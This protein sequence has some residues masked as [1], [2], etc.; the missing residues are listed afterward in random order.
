[1]HMVFVF[2]FHEEPNHR[3]LEYAC[4]LTV[5]GRRLKAALGLSCF[6]FSNSLL[7]TWSLVSNYLLLFERQRVCTSPAC[8]ARAKVKGD[9]GR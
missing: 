4:G 3:D 7:S 5:Q 8:T 1:M 6:L 9:M 2:L